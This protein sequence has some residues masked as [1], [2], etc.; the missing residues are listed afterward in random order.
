MKMNISDVAK[1]VGTIGTFVS[2]KGGNEDSA[3]KVKTA[4]A[5]EASKIL[6]SRNGEQNAETVCTIFTA[7]GCMYAGAELGV[8]IGTGIGFMIGGPLGASVGYTVGGTTG[9]TTGIVGGIKIANKI[10]AKFL[11]VPENEDVSDD[12][13]D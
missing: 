1:I 6:F 7:G 13:K 12:E 11:F 4:V 3:V 9:V 2:K 10:K 8:V 5:V